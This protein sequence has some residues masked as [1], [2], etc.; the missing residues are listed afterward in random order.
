[1]RHPM[2]IL[3]ASVAAAALAAGAEDD[4]T[5]EDLAAAAEEAAAETEEMVEDAADEIAETADEIGAA[6]DDAAD[7][8]DAELQEA[9]AGGWRGEED[10]AR[11]QHRH[12][13]ETLAFFGIEPDMTVAEVTPGGGWYTKIL[14][15][16]LKDEGQYVN[17]SFALDAEN[18][19]ARQAMQRFDEAY[20][21]AEI[22]GDVEYAP[23]LEVGEEGSTVVGF[24]EPGRFDAVLTFRNVHNWIG[25]DYAQEM[26]DA[27]YEGVKPGGVLGVVEH[28]LPADREGEEP[29]SGGYVREAAV[30]EMAQNAGF[31][32]EEKSEIN[33]NPADTAD[34][35]FGVWT[36]PPVARTS[37]F[38][39]DPDPEFDRSKYDAIGESDRMT[40]R[41]R[42]PAEPDAALLE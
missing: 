36:L 27:F 21:D 18:E 29:S 25:G 11:D 33:A 26:F 28:R 19:R 3:L 12:P 6:M 31:V 22:Y 16:Y 20:S 30:I 4:D 34:H 41:F 13:A 39:N 38:G 8:T 14:A 5:A 32:L 17:A 35:P 40:L 37:A 10:K 42:K 7:E 15:P 2:T 24:D 23:I 1:M 9:V